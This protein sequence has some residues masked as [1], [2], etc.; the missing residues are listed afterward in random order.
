MDNKQFLDYE[1]LILYTSLLAPLEK[2]DGA[3]SVQQ[4]SATL[5]EVAI[6][7]AEATGFQ[8]V[9]LGGMRPDKL[10][11]ANRSATSAEGIQSFAA[12]GCAHAYG[13]FSMALG[14]DV[15]AYMRGSIALGGGGAEAGMTVAEFN[16]KF[17]TAD[18]KALA[19]YDRTKINGGLDIHIVDSSKEHYEYPNSYSF[20]LAHG[21]DSVSKGRVSVAMGN[22]VKAYGSYSFVTNSANL[23]KGEDTAAFG[24]NNFT[25]NG[26][27]GTF[28]SGYQNK[29]NAG[30]YNHISGGTN[31]VNGGSW[32]NI[33]GSDNVQYSGNQAHI[34]GKLNINYSMR[35]TLAGF[36]NLIGNPT[37]TVN[38][39]NGPTSPGNRA[40]RSVEDGTG[41]STKEEIAAYSNA[42]GLG[43][44]IYSKNSTV[45]GLQNYT[46]ADSSFIF[47]Y[48]NLVRA[49]SL[50][51]KQT[52]LYYPTV[53][54]GTNYVHGNGRFSFT[55]GSDNDVSGNQSAAIGKQNVVSHERA[56][57]LNAFNIT[58][59]ECQTVIG[60]YSAQDSNALFVVGNGTSSTNRKNAFAINANGAL[61]LGG[62]TLTPS[63]LTTLKTATPLT[64]R[65]AEVVNNFIYGDE[66]TD[67]YKTPLQPLTFGYNSDNWRIPCGLMVIYLQLSH[68]RGNYGLYKKSGVIYI[69][70]DWGCEVLSLREVASG[71]EYSWSGHLIIRTFTQSS[72]MGLM[73]GTDDELS[74]STD[75]SSYIYE[76]WEVE[77]SYQMLTSY[78]NN[79]NW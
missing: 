77:A 78:Q 56:V 52:D 33:E 16:D 70:P 49:N 10:D 46:D 61:N 41:H 20:A 51:G 38:Y 11:D 27:N 12:G 68:K 3:G 76:D 40:F 65:Q 19:G 25:E 58:G 72:G 71:G 67:P 42:T 47:G 63:E 35:T 44:E 74:L 13:D 21:Q 9:A 48:R 29:A 31:T 64:T 30:M 14:K 28:I 24:Y 55:A 2:G 36:N 57:A 17:A 15:K 75:L 43:N 66:N 5:D 69:P 79:G 34:G 62:V 26:T 23:V 22:Q 59:R 39:A 8:A 1:G 4:K 6:P 73:F 18:Q 60:K 53:F 45:A 50:S 32:S 37:G 7:G 54:G